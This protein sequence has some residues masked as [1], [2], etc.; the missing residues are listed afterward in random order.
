MTN[1]MTLSL[2]D[3]SAFGGH[4]T[5][6]T[7]FGAIAVLG[8]SLLMSGCAYVPQKPMI[9]GPTTAQRRQRLNFSV[10]TGNE[11]RLPADV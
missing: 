4:T 6:R 5:S 11:L 8:L 9:D 10:R 7:R 2:T 3:K 1:D